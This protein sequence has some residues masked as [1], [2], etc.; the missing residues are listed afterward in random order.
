MRVILGPM[1]TL[2]QNLEI[3]SV[4][5]KLKESFDPINHPLSKVKFKYAQLFFDIVYV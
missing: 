1:L 2:L 5:R 4:L 3:G